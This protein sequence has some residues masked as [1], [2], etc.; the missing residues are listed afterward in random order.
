MEVE[1][2]AVST[3]VSLARDVDCMK[4]AGRSGLLAWKRRRMTTSVL[5]PSSVARARQEI[6]LASRQFG[7][8]GIRCSSATD[9]VAVRVNSHDTTA[10]LSVENLRRQSQLRIP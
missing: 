9:S 4:S 6:H 5:S 2:P 3:R 7:Q 8:V 1:S 10:L